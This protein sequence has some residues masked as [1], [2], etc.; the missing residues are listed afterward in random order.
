MGFPNFFTSFTSNR[1][2]HAKSSLPS[3]IPLRQNL[4][5]HINGSHND[6]FPKSFFERLRHR[7]GFRK[8]IDGGSRTEEEEKVY[9]WLYAL[10]QTDRDLVFEYVRSTERG[11]QACS[12]ISLVII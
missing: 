10:A 8:T 12:N 9:S 11:K 6:S 5:G 7:L 4:V 3:Y 1:Q 2:K